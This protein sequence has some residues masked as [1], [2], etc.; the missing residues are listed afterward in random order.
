MIM[1]GL[2]E[3]DHEMGYRTGNRGSLIISSVAAD[4][5][6]T[7]RHQQNWPGNGLINDLSAWHPTTAAVATATAST[8][9]RRRPPVQYIS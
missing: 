4:A 6:A 9:R 8:R 1:D 5:A 2:S 3:A 7:T